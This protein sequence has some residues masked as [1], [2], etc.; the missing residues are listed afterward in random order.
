[1]TDTEGRFAVGASGTAI[2]LLKRPNK[3]KVPFLALDTD[4]P[5]CLPTT[6]GLRAACV[7]KK[8]EGKC[9]RDWRF[10][11]ANELLDQPA[12]PLGFT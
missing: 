6:K 3:E 9:G 12:R 2:Q 7:L 10:D 4:V 8:A 1:M 11:E 5:S